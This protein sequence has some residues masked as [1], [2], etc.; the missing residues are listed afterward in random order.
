MKHKLL[1]KIF[2]ASLAFFF[3]ASACASCIRTPSGFRCSGSGPMTPRQ[4]RRVF[5]G[6]YHANRGMNRYLRHQD[7]SRRYNAMHPTNPF[8]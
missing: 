4:S 1:Q 5:R 2:L 7:Q 6:I 8:G 3:A